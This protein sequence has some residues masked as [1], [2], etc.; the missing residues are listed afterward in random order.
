M[1]EKFLAELEGKITG[2]RVLPAEG[3]QPHLE[4]SYSG[5]GTFNGRDVTD[6]ITYV[7]KTQ[8][9][10]LLFGTEDGVIT[11]SDGQDHAVW[12]GTGVGRMTDGAVT[13]SACITIQSAS[14]ALRT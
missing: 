7:A 14:P 8:T 13:W 2:T 11:A 10:G 4:F 6:V 9:E 12:H 1:T 3:A 5:G